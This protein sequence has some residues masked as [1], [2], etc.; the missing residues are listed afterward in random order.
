LNLLLVNR[1]NV[2]LFVIMGTGD[3]GAENLLRRV[4][5]PAEAA[6]ILR[7]LRHDNVVPFPICA[8]T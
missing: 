6:L 4:R 5:C 3:E 2:F 7:H 8:P 1:R